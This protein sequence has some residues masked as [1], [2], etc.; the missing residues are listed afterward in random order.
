LINF[1]QGVGGGNC[2]CCPALFS[3]WRLRWCVRPVGRGCSY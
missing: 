3:W 1:V 2:S